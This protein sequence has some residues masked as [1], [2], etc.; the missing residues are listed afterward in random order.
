MHRRSGTT[1]SSDCGMTT[2]GDLRGLDLSLGLQLP[3]L[4]LTAATVTAGRELAAYARGEGRVRVPTRSSGKRPPSAPTTA[5]ARRRGRRHV[6]VERAERPTLS[7][8]SV[9]A[10]TA[11]WYFRFERASLGTW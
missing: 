4:P 1:T 10:A 5:A 6:P 7:A 9:T 2:T 11:A 8:A 3:L